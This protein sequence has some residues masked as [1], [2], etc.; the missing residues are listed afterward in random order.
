MWSYNQSLWAILNRDL[1]RIGCNI[2]RISPSSRCYD[3]FRSLRNKVLWWMGVNTHSLVVQLPS[4]IH[5]L[6]YCITMHTTE[7]I[8]LESQ[9]ETKSGSYNISELI[10]W[11][12]ESFFVSPAQYHRIRIF[13]FRLFTNATPHNIGNPARTARQPK[14]H[15]REASGSWSTVQPWAPCMNGIHSY[16]THLI[17]IC[18]LPSTTHQRGLWR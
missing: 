2:L 1:H 11:S 9:S 16:L 10:I 12:P 18:H 3:Y 4:I 13:V 8:I 14:T 7:I 15:Y 6:F 17:L 5:V